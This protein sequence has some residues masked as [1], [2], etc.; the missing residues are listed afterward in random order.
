MRERGNIES[1]SS[2]EEKLDRSMA[3]ATRR[4]CNENCCHKHLLAKPL[5][6]DK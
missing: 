2:L 4:T 5:A 6:K 3:E 1:G